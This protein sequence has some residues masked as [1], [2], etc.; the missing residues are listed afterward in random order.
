MRTRSSVISDTFTSGHTCRVG[1][2]TTSTFAG[3]MEVKRIDDVSTPEFTRRL[4]CGEFL[5]INPVIIR[6]SRMLLATAAEAD[7]TNPPNLNYPV[8]GE[9]GAWSLFPGSPPSAP[10]LPPGFLSSE[11]FPFTPDEGLE[12]LV[13]TIARANAVAERW[14]VLT[15]LAEAR[16]TIQTMSWLSK[17]FWKK[18]LYVAQL[19]H[20]R[21]KS[22]KDR[23]FAVRDAVEWFS[24]NW[25]LAR[26]GIRPILYDLQD[27]QKYLNSLIGED[28]T[29]FVTG[30][31]KQE[32]SRVLAS[33]SEGGVLAGI[34]DVNRTF[35]VTTAD[36]YRAKA[37]VGAQT[38][39][40]RGLQIDPLVTAWEL[41]PFSFVFDWV[42]DI[43]G[44]LS[45]LTPTVRGEFLGTSLSFKSSRTWTR[46]DTISPKAGLST[47]TPGTSS[48]TYEVE[49]YTRVPYSGGT[50]PRLNFRF[51]VPKL[52]DLLAL[53]KRS[54]SEVFKLLNR[55]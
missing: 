14:D 51:N 22:R 9:Y 8:K 43:G 33:R 35:Q 15:A 39:W 31:S 26:Y 32:D 29:P 17:G 12:S 37:Y 20:L 40:S 1:P 30:R 2:S 48:W 50:L 16:S 46:T 44:W 10:G 38:G 45:T 11:Q 24:E 19:A 53:A 25:L 55:R 41:V 36:T 13:I 7:L 5:P 47:G 6:T 23:R 34:Y 27:A 42:V 3:G 54:R 28:G 49:Y 4:R 21:F 52:I 18:S